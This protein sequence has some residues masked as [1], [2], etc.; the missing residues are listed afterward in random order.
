MSVGIDIGERVIILSELEADLVAGGIVVPHGVTAAGP[1]TD[2]DF[3]DPPALATPNDPWP[4]GSRVFTT[5]D[6]GL[7]TDL[8]PGSDAI[9]AA[10]T[11]GS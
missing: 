8:P 7:P 6:V 5:D 11:P 1:A 9:V 10:Y 4:A 2:P 3:A